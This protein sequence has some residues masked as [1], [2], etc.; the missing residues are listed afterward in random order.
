MAKV[1]DGATTRKERMIEMMTYIRGFMPDGVGLYQVQL[2][3]SLVHGLKFTTTER[4]ITELSLG[5]LIRLYGGK[6]FLDVSEFDQLMRLIAPDVNPSLIV[7]SKPVDLPPIDTHTHT[8]ETPDS[9]TDNEKA[10]R[11]KKRQRERDER[12]RYTKEAEG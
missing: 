9:A 12:G 10:G 1:A 3:M 2:H 5:R 7:S 8:R 6:L 11:K 4:Y